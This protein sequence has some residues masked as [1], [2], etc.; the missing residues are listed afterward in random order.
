M[1]IALSASPHE[2]GFLGSSTYANTSDRLT[3]PESLH[4]MYFKSS[5]HL[6]AFARGKAHQ[7]GWDWWVRNERELGDVAISHEIYE[8]PEG[9]WETI[10]ANYRPSNF[11]E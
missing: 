9:G 1:S 4:I 2:Y 10:Y 7:E 11:G 3:Q 5:A 8:V 6:H